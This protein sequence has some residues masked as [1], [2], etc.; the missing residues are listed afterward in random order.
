[1]KTI[2]IM[3]RKNNLPDFSGYSIVFRIGDKI[4]PMIIDKKE[5]DFDKLGEYIKEGLEHLNY[6]NSDI[7][8]F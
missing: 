8:T 1:M 7:I 3:F 5:F 2:S 4:L 6:E